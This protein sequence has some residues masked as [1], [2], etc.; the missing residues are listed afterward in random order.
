MAHRH[1]LLIVILALIALNSCTQYRP[2]FFQ[3][4]DILNPS[5]EVRKS[6]LGFTADGNLIVSPAF[7]TWVY[8]LKQEI[9]KLR[10]GR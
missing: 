6:P 1:K 3:G 10:K 2:S 7:I 5:E 4:Y 8:E 9:I